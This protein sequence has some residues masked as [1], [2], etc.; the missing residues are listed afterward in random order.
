MSGDV[1]QPLPRS[2]TSSHMACIDKSTSSFNLLKD[3]NED[4]NNQ[5][6]SDFIAGIK[7]YR[8]LNYSEAFEF[9]KACEEAYPPAKYQIAC[10]H[11]EG[12]GGKENYSLAI[13]LMKEV[14][15]SS[16][17]YFTDLI[18]CAQY[19]I[20]RAYYE[21]FG[22]KQSD[23]EAEKWWLNA[24]QNGEPTGCIKAQSIL[25]MFYSRR[26][27]DNLDLKKSHYWHQEA[28]GNGS[29]ESQATL[30]VMYEHG[31]GVVKN[32]EFSFKCFKS[33]AQRGNIF[34]MGNLA[35]H[36]YRYKMFR[37]CFDVAKRLSVLTDTAQ[38]S[39]DTDCL[40]AYIKKGIA[41]GLF[42]YGRCLEKGVVENTKD[43]KPPRYWYSKAAI[44]EPDT[45]QYMQDLVSH[46]DI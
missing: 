7:A 11:Y 27:E 2:I 24:A 26:G 40:Q 28:T 5:I 46:G 41:I 10:M 3:I 33:A 37:N 30:G 8:D 16:S 13:K 4:G 38:L 25:A 43:E 23:T 14:I 6:P 22:V 19:N 32:M 9:F 29:L 36:Y 18:P 1:I 42:L 35:L 34:A 45:A 20:G 31:I 39:R 15:E 12:L 44:M 21:G 17:Y